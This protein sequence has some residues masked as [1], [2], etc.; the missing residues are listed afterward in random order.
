MLDWAGDC[1]EVW[2]PPGLKGGEGVPL[3][4]A[5]VLGH[6]KPAHSTQAEGV[7]G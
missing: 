2:P 3:T 1:C 4:G 6:L 5:V 7:G